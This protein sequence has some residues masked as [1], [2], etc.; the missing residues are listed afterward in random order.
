MNLGSEV[1][2]ITGRGVVKM[3]FNRDDRASLKIRMPIDLRMELGK[4]AQ[5][6]D[7]SLN[8]LINIILKEYINNNK[9]VKK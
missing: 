9:S 6:N 2:K 3:E 1:V 4:I 5:K 7:M 8:R